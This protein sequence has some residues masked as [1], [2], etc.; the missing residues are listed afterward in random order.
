MR[1]LTADPGASPTNSTPGSRHVKTRSLHV[2]LRSH[3]SPPASPSAGLMKGKA[4]MSSTF[5][6][7]NLALPSMTRTLQRSN[8]N[9]AAMDSPCPRPASP[10]KPSPL[11]R[12]PSQAS[13]ATARKARRVTIEHDIET[14]SGKCLRANS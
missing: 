2:P 11:P 5:T 8:L 6:A 9:L 4:Y 1:K 12:H 14:L 3:E 13:N 7:V 10:D